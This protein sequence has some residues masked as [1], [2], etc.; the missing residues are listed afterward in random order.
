MTSHQ[1]PDPLHHRTAPASNAVSMFSEREPKR[2]AL[3]A[4]YTNE[5][6]VRVLQNI[7]YDV[8]FCKGTSRRG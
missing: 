3:H 4:H 5:M 7:G 8:G 2:Y 1:N 6:M